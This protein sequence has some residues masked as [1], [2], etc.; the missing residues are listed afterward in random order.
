MIPANSDSNDPGNVPP[1]LVSPAHSS[2][3]PQS[4][5]QTTVA[6]ADTSVPFSQRE[7]LLFITSSLFHDALAEVRA[8]VGM[9]TCPSPPCAWVRTASGCRRASAARQTWTSRA[10]LLHRTSAVA[11]RISF[12]GGR[13]GLAQAQSWAASSV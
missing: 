12:E 4:Q 7:G 9:S 2:K 1:G 10:L 6:T 8:Q 13:V 5:Y 3:N 11:V